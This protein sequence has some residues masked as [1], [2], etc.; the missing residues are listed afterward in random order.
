MC[1]KPAVDVNYREFGKAMQLGATIITDGPVYI[2]TLPPA[3]SEL[4]LQVTPVTFEDPA[5]ERALLMRR[6]NDLEYGKT[7]AVLAMTKNDAARQCYATSHLWWGWTLVARDEIYT[8]Q[9]VVFPKPLVADLLGEVDQGEV[10]EIETK[11][12][13]PWDGKNHASRRVAA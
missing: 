9:L 12:L 4:V 3:P 7:S 10:Y 13:L 8:I 1:K 2:D 6:L 11:K 5:C